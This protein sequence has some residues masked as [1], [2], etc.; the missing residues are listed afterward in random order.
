MTAVAEALD[1]VAATTSVDV[2]DT[3]GV[4]GVLALVAD[5]LADGLTESMVEV[6]SRG[7]E[8]VDVA[9]TTFTTGAGACSTESALGGP[10][11]V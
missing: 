4:A 7:P 2:V 10:G 6:N 9:L 11:T 8:E 1:V 5:V 3:N